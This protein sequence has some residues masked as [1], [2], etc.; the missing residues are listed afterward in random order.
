MVK[1]KIS[2][3]LE[4]KI[5]KGYPW[6]F[7]YQLKKK[8]TESSNGLA[9]LYDHKNRF[10]AIGLWDP[11]SDLCFRV[12][13]LSESRKIDINFFLE[14]F[15]KAL[16]LR[17]ALDSHGTTG[18][19]I[20]NGENAGFPGLILDRYSNTWVVKV[21][22]ISW[23]AHLEKVLETIQTEKNVERVV[24]RLSRNVDQFSN[25]FFDGQI[26]LGSDPITPVQFLEN[27]LKF[28]VDVIKGQKTG[29][30]LDQRD[31][32]FLVKNISY[33]LSVLNVFS[34]TGGFSIY[35][36]SGGCRKLVEIDS[37]SHAL[38]YSLQNLKLNFPEKKDLEF[39]QIEGDAFQKLQALKLKNSKFDLVIL[40]PPAFAR[41]KKHKVQA[42][43]AYSRLTK[44]GVQL[45]KPGGRFIS[46]SC[47][48]HVSLE[49]FSKAVKQGVSSAQKELT[50]I[51]ITGHGIDHPI[52]F[53]EAKYLKCI[54]G[55]IGEKN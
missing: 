43:E 20:L 51:C 11:T 39:Q 1:I 21:Y 19:R 9:V 38:N 25:Q 36:I 12:L 15:K 27:G 46:A 32:R 8:I 49:E 52:E 48:A 16:L 41:K 13:N 23:F 33:G 34:Y 50:K 31:N 22:T 30:F 24:L 37:N 17:E 7:K 14:R 40:D 3:T 29:F 6:V 26:L 28:N 2:K 53:D 42:L 45:V 47:S 35:A 5:K 44:L 18:Y 54:M 55:W 4:A 10:L